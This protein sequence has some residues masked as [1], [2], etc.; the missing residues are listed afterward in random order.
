MII[1]KQQHEFHSFEPFK[2]AVELVAEIK[3]LHQQCEILADQLNSYEAHNKKVRNICLSFL[4]GW[5]L[6]LIWPGISPKVFSNGL[7]YLSVF[8]NG[9]T[10]WNFFRLI[11]NERIHK[12]KVL[13][14]ELLLQQLMSKIPIEPLI[15]SV[16]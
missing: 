7:I 1:A 2:K 16:N 14:L 3:E 13:E 8:Y 4:V 11:R 12:K 15:S 5:L 10:W 9:M 6:L